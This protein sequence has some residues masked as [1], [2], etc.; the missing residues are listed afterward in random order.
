M[1]LMVPLI[2]IAVFVFVMA[3]VG[4]FGYRTYA[5][6]ANLLE[7][8]SAPPPGLRD[9]APGGYEG[10]AAQAPRFRVRKALMW[11]GE[12]VPVSPEEASVTSRMLLSAGYKSEK[13]LP[14]FM[15]IRVVSACGFLALAAALTSATNWIPMA[16]VAVL[17]VSVGLGYW[18]PQLV[19]EEMLIPRYQESLR[20]ALPDALDMLVVCVEA[21]ISLDQAIRMVSEELDLTHPI[22]C[23][24]LKLISV[25]MRAGERRAQALKN[26]AER[27]REPE[28][29]KLVALLVQTDRFG[30]SVGEALRTHSEFMRVARRQEAQEKAGKLGVKLVIPIFFFILPTIVILTAAPAFIQIM[31]S[32]KS[33]GKR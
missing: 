13:A 8:L 29:A 17:V 21:G 30:T 12:K 33:V 1:T 24:E 18:L 22:L 32:L 31:S 4:Y 11:L 26:L 6:S 20:Y 5:R 9:F 15:A 23:R 10:G 27:T 3:T 19:L 14:I 28:I 2:S 7:K 16:D 25:E